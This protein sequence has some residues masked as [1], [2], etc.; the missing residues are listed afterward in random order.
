MSEPEPIIIKVDSKIT[1]EEFAGLVQRWYA[2]WERDKG[3]PLRILPPADRWLVF[4]VGCLECGV[5]SQPIGVYDTEDQA[6]AAGKLWDEQGR[7][8]DGGQHSVQV[9]DLSEEWPR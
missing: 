2:A 7:E 4:D 3:K 8:P 1:S 9:F 5:R 6:V